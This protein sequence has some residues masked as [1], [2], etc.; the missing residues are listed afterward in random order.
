MLWHRF[1]GRPAS[2]YGKL[3][4]GDGGQG[5]GPSYADM[6]RR[7][8]Y[9]V[10]RILKGAKAGD[11]PVERPAKFDLVINMKAAKAF[12]LTIPQSVL[13]RATEVIQ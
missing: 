6:H 4:H 12:G 7:A 8:A 9:F 1:L 10:D 2:E 5:R 13:L 3:R 11:L